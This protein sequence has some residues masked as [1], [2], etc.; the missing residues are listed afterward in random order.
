MCFT[1]SP[2]A[3]FWFLAWASIVMFYLS[4][5]SPPFIARTVTCRNSW[6][7]RRTMKSTQRQSSATQDMLRAHVRDP[8]V[9]GGTARLRVDGNIYLMRRTS[10]ATV[11]VISSSGELLRILKI[12]PAGRRRTHRGGVQPV[13][14][15]RA[16]ISPSRMRRPARSCLAI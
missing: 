7:S 9:S 11:Y 8:G 13:F 5:A 4:R 2:G 6:R 12:E 16:R 3:D 1:A 14:L 10:P 15:G